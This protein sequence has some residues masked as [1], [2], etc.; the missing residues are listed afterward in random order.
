MNVPMPFVTP[1]EAAN[2]DATPPRTSR[3]LVT[4]A[5]GVGVLAVGV[6]TAVLGQVVEV[7]LTALVVGAALSLLNEDDPEALALGCLLL[8]PAGASLAGDL[9]S[10]AIGPPVR[11]LRALALVGATVGLAGLWTG[12]PGRGTLT[13]AVSRFGYALFPLSITALGAVVAQLGTGEAAALGRPIL[14]ALWTE[15][16]SPSGP[17]PRLADFLLLLSASAVAVRAALD[18]LPVA[19]LASKRTVDRRRRQVRTARAHLRTT[20]R[21]GGPAGIVLGVLTVVRAGH[22]A[23]LPDPLVA[24]L[25]GVASL[26]PLRT[27]LVVALLVS[28]VAIAVVDAV[29]WAREAAAADVAPRVVPFA[30]GVGFVLAVWLFTGAV[31][32]RVRARTPSAALPVLEE[33][34]AAVGATPVALLVVTATL[35]LFAG[36]AGAVVLL[37]RWNFLSD[38]VAPVSI[39][40]AGV[41]VA[42]LVSGVVGDG[43]TTVF[44]GVGAAMVAWDVGEFGV[45]VS[46]E[47][48]REAWSRQGE[49]A[50]ALASAAVAA[51]GVVAAFVLYGA[52]RRPVLDA[53]VTA[54]GAVAAFV[55]TLLLLSRLR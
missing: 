8:A 16:V 36:L 7:G 19:E 41:F 2:G 25:G 30:A 6:Q 27:L 45:G 26:S 53:S 37:G 39:A 47:L 4:A 18:R 42:A 35:L 55:G 24:L 43:A 34:V 11:A 40:S 22:Y 28:A 10:I 44:V 21:V 31:L 46:E 29:T 48:G 52:M 12:V 17:G 14:D 51:G 49:F 13:V 33:L 23:A 32:G 38:R 54:V 20:Y 9:V 5:V 3:M 1:T 15:L 50:H